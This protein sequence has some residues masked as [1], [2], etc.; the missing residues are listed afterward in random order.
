MRR[1]LSAL[2]VSALA[3]VALAGAVL[4]DTTPSYELSVAPSEP[5]V[6]DAVLVEAY[7]HFGTKP[8]QGAQVEFLVTGP[9]ISQPLVLHGKPGQAG[10]YRNQFTAQAPGDFEIVTKVDGKQLIAKPYHLQISGAPASSADW[11]P[12]AAAGGALAILA[13]LAA[14]FALR[15]IRIA[16]AM[17]A[18][19]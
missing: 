4:A 13:G 3:T 17:T 19:N 6:G 18:T 8:Y 16:R 5:K 2:L 11:A 9:G 15:K 7:V 1:I 10:Y 14:A 12:L